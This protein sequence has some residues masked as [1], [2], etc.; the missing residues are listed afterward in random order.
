MAAE[1]GRACGCG[2]HPSSPAKQQ[3]DVGSTCCPILKACSF[4]LSNRSRFTHCPLFIH[5]PQRDRSPGDRHSPTEPTNTTTCKSAISLSSTQPACLHHHL[6]RRP[7]R[8]RCL[9]HREVWAPC[10]GAADES[11]MPRRPSTPSFTTTTRK[12]A[13]ETERK[14]SQRKSMWNKHGEDKWK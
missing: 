11:L 12:H 14:G 10:N 9:E 2:A 7:L 1:S 6:R 3:G 5:A 8:R 13:R 4:Y